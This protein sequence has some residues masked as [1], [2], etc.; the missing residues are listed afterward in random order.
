MAYIAA[1][2]ADGQLATGAAGTL[3]TAST[4]TILK[5]A[6]VASTV[7]GDV[8]T[9]LYVTRSGSSARRFFRA[10][11]SDN[12][13]A[14]FSDAVSLSSGDVLAGDATVAASVDYVL[15]GAKL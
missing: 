13:Y 1:S 10:V 12:D 2:L 7:T 9:R 6:S 8:T 11:L 5:F 15:T 3:Y 14:H 4:K